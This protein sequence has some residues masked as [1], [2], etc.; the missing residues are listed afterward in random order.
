M[1]KPIKRVGQS[2]K[3]Q[4]SKKNIIKALLKVSDKTWSKLETTIKNYP[5][6]IE[7]I[8]KGNALKAL[9]KVW[10]NDKDGK[11]QALY[12]KITG[13]QA[14]K[15]I[16]EFQKAMK[17]VE[18]TGQLIQ[19]AKTLKRHKLANIKAWEATEALINF[20]L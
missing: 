6:S 12:D 16:Q 7:E 18:Y 5:I 20:K 8:M 2:A 11:Y 3:K 14:I 13:E 9:N 19:T 1:K 4:P 15:L 17:E 10:G